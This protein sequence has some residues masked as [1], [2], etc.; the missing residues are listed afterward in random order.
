MLSY[1]PC[2][3]LRRGW[4]PG[5]APH[6]LST[7]PSV[8]SGKSLPQ[9]V[10]SLKDYISGLCLTARNLMTKSTSHCR[11]GALSRNKAKI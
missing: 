2:G 6:A 10:P 7:Q 5:A 1:L 9:M 4:E 8:L 3:S 11:V